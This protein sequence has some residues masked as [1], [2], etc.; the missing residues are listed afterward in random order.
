M[1]IVDEVT[2]QQIIDE[3]NERVKQWGRQIRVADDLGFTSSFISDV[4][5]GKR[6]VSEKLADSMGYTRRVIFERKR[7]R[8][9]P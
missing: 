4:R 8:R 3:L 5:M 6:P 7:K 1:S 2:E 9:Q